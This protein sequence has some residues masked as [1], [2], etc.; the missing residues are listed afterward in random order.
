MA[1]L[2]GLRAG[3]ETLGVRMNRTNRGRRWKI[4]SPNRPSFGFLE[5]CFE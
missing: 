4:P 3:V 1:D 2:D 5:A